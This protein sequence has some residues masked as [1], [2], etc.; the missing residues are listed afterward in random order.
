L[1]W[2]KLKKH[3]L[4]HSMAARTDA[5]GVEPVLKL[6]SIA[7][8]TDNSRHA[9]DSAVDP[10]P[11]D[12][13]RRTARG[14]FVSTFS[15]GASLLIR[16]ISMVVLARLL[17]PED[18][19]LVGMATAFTG[20]LVMFQ[21]GG[22][23]LAT[24]QR[25]SI[26]RSQTS[27]LFWI[28]L[29]LGGMLAVLSAA[30]APILARFYHEPRLL[31]VTVVIGL[32]FVFTGAAAQHG[33]MLRREMR[34]TVVTMIEMTSLLLTMAVGIGMA[35]AGRGYWALVATSLCPTLVNLLGVWTAGRWIP[36]LPQR[37]AGVLSMLRYGGS[38]MLN[39]LIAYFAYNADKVFIGRFWGAEA[40]GIYGRAYQIINLP[41]QTLHSSIG[42]VAFPA[43]SRV[44]NDPKRLRSYFLKGYGLFLT[45][46]LP[47]TMACA[48]YAEDIIQVFLG[49]KWS[50]AVPVFRLMTPATLAFALINPFGWLLMATGRTVR[51]LKIT[52]L[53]FPIV[54]FGYVGGL[55]YGP[56]GV[57]AGF[58][59]A[60][61]LLVVPVVLWATRGTSIAALD[62]LRAVMRPFLA[63]LI[64]AGA[65]LAAS[66]FIKLLTSPL[67][68]LIVAS[69]VLFG[70]YAVVLWL[71]MGQKA[72]YL[73]LLREIG[74][75]PLGS[76]R[77]EKSVEQGTA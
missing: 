60:M 61:V 71:V 32:G 65:A 45:L 18:F 41:T 16:I 8:F 68:R 72:I 23:S 66:N 2:I 62:T 20:F 55:S 56:I 75:W 12:L 42:L 46:V 14:A 73:G 22:L 37:R 10:V 21:D 63:V 26:T 29:A 70:V 36:G 27:T 33:A 19:G 40:L 49:S 48:L 11:D 69:A 44:Q 34:F 64:G 4:S 30:I 76:R 15:Q 6:N 25:A 5:A 74:I 43:L 7:D 13:K 57:A 17:S 77:Q 38:L 28:N 24:V 39:A 52:L 3:T 53:M 47:I 9:G 59:V 1:E 67:L 31:W 35:A 51:N 54:I 58:S 50:A